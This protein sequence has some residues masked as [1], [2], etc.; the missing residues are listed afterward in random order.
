MPSRSG[1][2]L[3][4]H[5]RA[6]RIGASAAATA[7]RRSNSIVIHNAREHNLKNIDVEIPRDRFT[8][9]TGVSGSGK[10]HAGFRHHVQ[11]RPAALSRI[12]ERLR[13]PVRAAR[14]APGRGCDLRHP[15]DGGDRAAHQP[16]RP[17]EH[18]GHAHRDLPLPAAALREARHAVLPG[19]RRAHRAAERRVHRRAPAARL[20]RQAHRAARA[21]GGARKGYYTDLAKWAREEGFKHLRVDGEMLPTEPVAAPV[22]LQGTHHRAAGGRDRRRPAQRARSCAQALDARA[23]F[24]QGLV[25]VLA[26]WRSWTELRVDRQSVFS[27]KRACPSCGTQLRRAR[28]APVLV[29]LQAR[30][31]RELLRHRARADEVDSTRS[32][33]AK[34]IMCWNVARWRE[35]DE[36]ARPATAS[37]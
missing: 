23:G 3:L 6:G 20:P 36:P 14:G 19:L 26:P 30:L 35:V 34:K 9:I 32:R 18:G 4:A 5:R 12:A 28:S 10:I 15:A 31:V 8:V 2:E 7:A 29:Q 33:A 16:R 37:A 25:H 27:T 24:R 13:A 21:A 22:A 17:Q 1:A 11:R